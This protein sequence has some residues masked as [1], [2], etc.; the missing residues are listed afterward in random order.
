MLSLNTELRF[1]A[2]VSS[3]C[4]WCLAPLFDIDVSPILTGN[5]ALIKAMEDSLKIGVSPSKFMNIKAYKDDDIAK[6]LDFKLDWNEKKLVFRYPEN[7]GVVHIVIYY[8][9]EYINNLQISQNNLY[10]KRI[11]EQSS[12]NRPDET[13]KGESKK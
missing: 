5:S 6:E 4:L 9:H 3:Y 11:K 12:P 7:E 10:E 8:D 13:S 1:G 2:L